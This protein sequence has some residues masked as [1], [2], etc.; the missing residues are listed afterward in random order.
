[1]GIYNRGYQATVTGPVNP[2]GMRYWDEADLYN[3]TVNHVPSNASYAQPTNDQI[4]SNPAPT[5][6]NNAQSGNGQPQINP[7]PVE[8]GGFA[9]GQNATA[10]AYMNQITQNLGSGTAACGGNLDLT[11]N[12]LWNNPTTIQ[13]MLLQRCRQIYPNVQATDLYDPANPGNG[14]L[15]NGQ[16]DLGNALYIYYDP[17]AGKLVSKLSS[18]PTLPAWITQ[19]QTPP[20]TTIPSGT[21]ANWG[22]QSGYHTMT[23]IPDGHTINCS[24]TQFTVLVSGNESN[25]GVV[26][27]AIGFG[28]AIKGDLDLHDQPFM[29]VS[30]NANTQDAVVFRTSSGANGLLG[31]LVFQNKAGIGANASGGSGTFSAPN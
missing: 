8:P 30:A 11:N 13:G 22:V 10:A 29:S 6:P 31:D 17:T 14:L 21:L 12:T 18:D 23:P 4:G 27:A 19:G 15:S 24:E 2:S 7:N 5:I 9:F 26:D 25:S 1:M 16:L 20:T 28:G 3:E